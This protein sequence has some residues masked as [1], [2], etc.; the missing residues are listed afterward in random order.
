MRFTSAAYYRNTRL[1]VDPLWSPLFQGLLYSC[2]V[3]LI[4]L[5]GFLLF[6]FLFLTLEYF[7]AFVNIN[8]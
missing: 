7:L 8:D 5:L 2:R 1:V 6:A 4:I 3:L